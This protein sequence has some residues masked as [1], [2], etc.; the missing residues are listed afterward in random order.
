[1]YEEQDVKEKIIHAAIELIEESEGD[2]RNITL[3]TIAKR[4]GVG[5]GLINYHFQ[6]KDNLITICIQRIIHQVVFRFRDRK[7]R[8]NETEAQSDKERLTGWAIQVFEFLFTNSAVSR[9]S[10]LGDM[11]DYQTECNSVNTQRDFMMALKENRNEQAKQLLIFMLTASMQVAF[12]SGNTS[13]EIL[14]YDLHRKEERD[15]FITRTVSM[16]FE[17]IQEERT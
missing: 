8:E 6:S 12:L 17:G 5:L 11:A 10:I 16:L 7:Q 15:I 13:K 2:T 14:G 1:M 4:A 9:I 3:R